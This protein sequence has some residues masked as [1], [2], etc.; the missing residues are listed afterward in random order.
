MSANCSR[1]E[2]SNPLPQ[3]IDAASGQP[4][5]PVELTGNAAPNETFTP[6]LLGTVTSAQLQMASTTLWF[7]FAGL[8]PNAKSRVVYVTDGGGTTLDQYVTVQMGVIMSSVPGLN[9]SLGSHDRNANQSGTI[10]NIGLSNYFG[11][12]NLS[13]PGDTL[14]VGIGTGATLTTTGQ[15]AFYAVETL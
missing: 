9:A 6:T 14:E 1:L 11:H 5:Q 4:I 15:V 12:A 13:D 10:A 2:V 3:S 8:R 7:A